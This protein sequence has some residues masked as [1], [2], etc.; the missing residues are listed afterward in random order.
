MS[1]K[2]REL[3]SGVHFAP[4]N[5][6]TQFPTPKGDE[7]TCVLIDFQLWKVSLGEYR[8]LEDFLQLYLHFDGKG[9]IQV[10]SYYCYYYT[11]LQNTIEN[12]YRNKNISYQNYYLQSF[13]CLLRITQF[14]FH[15]VFNKLTA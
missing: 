13:E 7:Q 12:F 8:D 5:H 10:I 9:A 14:K 3:H 1:S 4:V 2:L 11:V 6:F 15:G